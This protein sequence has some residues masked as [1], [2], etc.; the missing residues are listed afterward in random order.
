MR[1]DIAKAS[2]ESFVYSSKW[3]KEARDSSF[4]N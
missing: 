4:V 2:I 1:W 3:P